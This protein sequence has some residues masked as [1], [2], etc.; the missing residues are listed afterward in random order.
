VL[1][2]QKPAFYSPRNVGHAGLGLTH[3][4]HF[5]SPIRRY[6]DLVVHRALLASLGID[7]DGPRAAGLDDA[8]RESSDAE[9]HAILVERDAADVCFAFL[10][11]RR[12]YEDGW[13]RIWDGEVVGLIGAG[14]FVSFG[15][16]QFEGFLPARRLR[17][18]W[19]G[20]NEHETALV[21]ARSGREL[22]IGDPVKVRVQRVFAP[23]GRVD[24]EPGE[25]EG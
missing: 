7:D 15:D 16:E 18:E 12:L 2:S 24:L 23:R 10:L 14:A 19:W 22:R 17:G 21:G 6:P 25:G 11:E 13:E 9:R 3:Y 8:G 4:C 1:R 20:L 5:T